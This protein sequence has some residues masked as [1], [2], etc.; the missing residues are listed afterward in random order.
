M[1]IMPVQEITEFLGKKQPLTFIFFTV[2]IPYWVIGLVLIL[3]IILIIIIIKSRRKRKKIKKRK[4]SKALSF[5][6]FQNIAKTILRLIRYV[7]FMR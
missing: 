2:P 6:N 5:K 4:K 3:I 7:Y 1:C